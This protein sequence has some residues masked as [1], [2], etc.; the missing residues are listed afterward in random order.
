[1]RT[2]KYFVFILFVLLLVRTVLATWSDFYIPI[3]VLVAGLAI[4]LKFR[5]ER[6]RLLKKFNARIDDVYLVGYAEG[7]PI[8]LAGLEDVVIPVKRSQVLGKVQ[9]YKRLIKDSGNKF[10]I[11]V[12]VI[13]FQ[14]GQY[15]NET[16]EEYIDRV[17][18][19]VYASRSE[20]HGRVKEQDKELYLS[21][22]HGINETRTFTWSGKYTGMNKVKKQN[23]SA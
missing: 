9:Y 22:K 16:T 5:L 10:G 1:M 4:W 15:I 12:Q 2:L 11:G 19:R 21:V 8:Y 18:E 7:R 6:V 13:L 17:R 23:G 3:G 20:Q 14:D